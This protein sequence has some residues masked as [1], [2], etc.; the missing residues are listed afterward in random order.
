MLTVF[1][2][3]QIEHS[4]KVE[5][6]L[7]ELDLIRFF[8]GIVLHITIMK[9][10]MIGMNMMKFPLSHPFRFRQWRTIYLLGFF[11]VVIFLMIEVTS[12]MFMLQLTNSVEIIYSYIRFI[13]IASFDPMIYKS[14]GG[15]PFQKILQAAPDKQVQGLSI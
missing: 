6:V 4:P 15:D 11:K 3:N 10:V 7:G 14:L 13:W 9:G 2:F 1:L 5:N 12:T 8:M